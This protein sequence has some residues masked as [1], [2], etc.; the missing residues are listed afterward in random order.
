MVDFP[1]GTPDIPAAV[2][3]N[4]LATF[5]TAEAHSTATNRILANLVALA[6]KLGIG[7][8]TP[9]ASAGVL[10]R[11]GTGQSGWGQ[12][13][14]G[15]YAAGSIADA[16]INAA[17][18]IGVAKIAQL[19]ICVAYTVGTTAITGT[20][21]PVPWTGEITDIQ[22]MH[23]PADNTKITPNRGTFWL[24]NV[25]GV[26]DAMASGTI[27]LELRKNGAAFESFTISRDPTGGNTNIRHITMLHAVAAGDYLQVALSQSSGSSV[28][29]AVGARFQVCYLGHN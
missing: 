21:T 25:Y 8:S 20:L 22:A 14:A 12:V 17:A 6:T 7:A 5:H 10:R 11:T 13:A 2:G 16:D 3:A 18:A 28:N 1:T 9:G 4:P 29:L 24:I 27:V 26:M 23:D 15:D 19:P